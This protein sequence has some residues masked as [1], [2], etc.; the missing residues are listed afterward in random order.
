M[1]LTLTQRQTVFEPAWNVG[2]P[3][4]TQP[5]SPYSRTK[6]GEDQ[7]GECARWYSCLFVGFH[8]VDL[9]SASVNDLFIPS[10]VSLMSKFLLC[11]SE[12]HSGLYVKFNS[13]CALNTKSLT[14]KALIL[15]KILIY[16][17]VTIR[18]WHGLSVIFY[19]IKLHSIL[20]L[21]VCNRFNCYYYFC[22]LH[23]TASRKVSTSR[24]Y[25]FT[26]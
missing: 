18:F 15:K 1:L 20:L 8:A 6:V 11:W 14:I 7:Q 3:L 23:L 17:S 2:F 25:S 24:H 16:S 21:P 10:Q 4:E 26:K 5:N 19:F 22:C 13:F 12:F 9:D